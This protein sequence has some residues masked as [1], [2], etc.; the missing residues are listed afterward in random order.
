MCT[1][2]YRVLVTTNLLCSTE[3]QSLNATTTVLF[4]D[5]AESIFPVQSLPGIFNV[6][7]KI[8]IIVLNTPYVCFGNI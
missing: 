2:N 1:F 3:H 4:H 7:C 8:L 5:L 6:G